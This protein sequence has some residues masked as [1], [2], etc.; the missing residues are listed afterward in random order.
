MKI[1]LIIVS[2]FL[3]SCSDKFPEQY[4]YKS[5]LKKNLCKRFIINTDSVEFT[6]DTLVPLEEC[7]SIYGFKEE[8][9]GRVLSWIRRIKE[10]VDKCTSTIVEDVL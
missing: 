6:F 7:S 4:L 2:L 5:D 1:Y 9:T 3:A 8:G 10:K